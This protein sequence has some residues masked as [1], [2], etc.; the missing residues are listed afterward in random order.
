[1][2]CSHKERV[3]SDESRFKI[4]FAE[5]QHLDPK[6]LPIVSQLY[7]YL[8]L[9][10]LQSHCNLSLTKCTQTGLPSSNHE[11]QILEGE[12]YFENAH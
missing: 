5:C 10:P 2:T 3:T 12:V 6:C 8:R 7:I 4:W 1:M 9:F 11:G